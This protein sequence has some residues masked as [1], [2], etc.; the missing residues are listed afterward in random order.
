MCSIAQLED[1][2]LPS[3]FRIT[4]VTIA[5]RLPFTNSLSST[6]EEIGTLLMSA[7]LYSLNS[8]TSR[9]RV[10]FFRDLRIRPDWHNVRL[11]ITSCFVISVSGSK[12]AR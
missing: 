1:H 6:D 12:S 9:S 8:D 4:P 5:D 3:P 7:S 10:R 11:L 2:R